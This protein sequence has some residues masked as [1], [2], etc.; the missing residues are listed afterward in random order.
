[1]KRV[2]YVTGLG[3]AL[4]CGLIGW[5]WYGVFQEEE[6][7]LL[8]EATSQFQVW[9]S[10]AIS[11]TMTGLLGLDQVPTPEAPAGIE[12]DTLIR[13][14]FRSSQEIELNNSD[15]LAIRID[16]TT[17]SQ[18]V[19]TEKFITRS[20]A[21]DLLT[22][23]VDEANRQANGNIRMVL[24]K[25]HEERAAPV[26]E[27]LLSDTLSGG[28]FLGKSQFRVGYENY[29]SYV[30]RQM[31]PEIGLGLLVIVSLGFAFWLT[32]RNLREQQLALAAKD[33]FI[34]NIT[35]E[36]KT[37]IATVGVALE[38]LE[39]FGADANPAR[40]RVPRYRAPGAR[41]A[42]PAYRTRARHLAVRPPR[43]GVGSLRTRSDRTR[44]RG[45]GQFVPQI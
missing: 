4:L 43:S 40:R 17:D 32:L 25:L 16:V 10:D 26:R 6:D 31:L 8:L 12:S 24:L 14:D 23:R 20:N 9:K 28:A 27:F 44:R 42:Q 21:A 1:M 11:E 5:W 15:S 34:S 13:L 18:R 33:N 19:V 30:L 39:N 29:R 41:P 37:P 7:R 2:Y 36:L 35:H 22:K 3:F 38:A 45:L